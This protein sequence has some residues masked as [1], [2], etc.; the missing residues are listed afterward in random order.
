MAV[1]PCRLCSPKARRAAAIA[2]TAAP[3]FNIFR[4]LGSITGD[5]LAVRKNLFQLI[6]D[7]GNARFCAGFLLGLATRCAAQADGAD[8]IVTNHDGNAAAKR[9]DIR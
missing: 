2:V 6:L 4:L 9:Y 1:P 7:L 8:R 5:L 3:V